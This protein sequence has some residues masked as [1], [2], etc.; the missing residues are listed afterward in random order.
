MIVSILN[1]IHDVLD[2]LRRVDFLGPLALRLYLAPVFWVSGMNKLTSFGNVVEWFG[3]AEWGLGLP[4][5]W[6]MAALATGAEVGGAV[7]LLSGL[8]T[9]LIAVPLMVTMIVAATMVHWDNGWQAVHDPQSAF[10]S[11]HVLGI[12]AGDAQAAIERLSRARVLLREHGNYEYL[13]AKGNFVVANNGIE[14]AATYFVMLLA[15]FFTG[16]GRWLS[17]DYW[18]AARWRRAR[19]MST[20]ATRLMQE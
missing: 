2:A 16:A 5:P 4:L 3:N 1:R 15:L 20:P 6:L 11:G 19:G 8:G 12:E 14:W 18:I 10:A 17:A 13:T 9:R 7:L